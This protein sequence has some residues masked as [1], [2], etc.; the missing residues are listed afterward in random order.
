MRPWRETRIEVKE[1]GENT[2]VIIMAKEL[3]T[4]HVLSILYQIDKRRF[5]ESR[6]WNNAWKRGRC[7]H[8]PAGLPSHINYIMTREQSDEYFRDNPTPPP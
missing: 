2:R 8:Y 1:E 5:W 6:H 7:M 4:W 3:E